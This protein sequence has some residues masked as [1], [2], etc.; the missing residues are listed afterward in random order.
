[1]SVVSFLVSSGSTSNNA[2]GI[3]PYYYVYTNLADEATQCGGCYSGGLTC[4][5][6][7]QANVD[8]LFIDSGCTSYCKCSTQCGCAGSNSERLAA[9]DSNIIIQCGCAGYC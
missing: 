6:C 2:C 9:G 4:W 8:T 1:M 7:L 3:G 5:P